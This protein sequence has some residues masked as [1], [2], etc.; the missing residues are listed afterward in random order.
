MLILYITIGVLYI[1]VGAA[2]GYFIKAYIDK[3]TRK[4]DQQ[5]TSQKVSEV[6]TEMEDKLKKVRQEVEQ[7]KQ[8]IRKDFEQTTSGKKVKIQQQSKE[9]EEKTRNLDRKA[10]LMSKKEKELNEKERNLRELKEKLDK[11]E[12]EIQHI[13][14]NEQNML[15]KISRMTPKEAR[16]RLMEQIAEEAREEAR[17]NYERIV[18]NAKRDAHREAVEII[19][20]AIQR[21]ASDV[22]QELTVSSVSIPDEEMKGRIIGREGRNIRSIEAETGV[23]LIIDDTPGLITIS[24]FDGVRREIAKR[25]LEILIKDGRIQPARIEEVVSSV[26]K[27]VDKII[28]KAWEDAVMDVGVVGL[29]DE[30]VYLIG[31][32]HYRTSYGQN[33][34]E[35]S[36]SV[37][38]LA[39]IMAEELEID[40][41]FARRA[42]I[43]HDIG[44]AIDRETQG[45]HADIGAKLAK[46]YGESERLQNAVLAHHEE[47][48]PQTAEAIL[49]QAAD[50]ISASRPGARREH[51]QQYIKRMTDIEEVAKE[52]E[53]VREAYCL[54]A[55]REIRIIVEPNKVT[56]LEAANVAKACAQ[57]IQ[58]KIEYPGEIKVTVIRSMR[59]TET[60]K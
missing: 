36:I 16:E 17:R 12:E 2:A 32:L 28:K 48:E 21:N 43:L 20:Q 49:I 7:E 30:L 44:K 35:H 19:A 31:K 60:A 29:H 50:A 18:E 23:N 59:S 40:A 55:G 11:Q 52:F 24:S 14:D 54:S 57:K 26:K 46:K 47:E 22:T 42:G 4:Y 1:A 41:D 8:R 38:Y 27:D 6:R 15:Q 37:S 45:N 56:D 58:E 5:D 51:V 10:D 39:G 34:L 9:I 53:G 3:A 25:S 33:V 13:K